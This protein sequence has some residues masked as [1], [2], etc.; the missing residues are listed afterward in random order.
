VVC[1]L[2]VGL[3]GDVREERGESILSGPGGL[4]LYE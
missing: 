4:V 2:P 1:P 3:H